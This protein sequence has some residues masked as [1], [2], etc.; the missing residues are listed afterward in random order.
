MKKITLLP[1]FL[2]GIYFGAFSQNPTQLASPAWVAPQNVNIQDPNFAL[3]VRATTPIINSGSWRGAIKVTGSEDHSPTIVWDRGGVIRNGVAAQNNFF[4]GG[5]ASSP[6]GDYFFGLQNGYGANVNESYVLQIYGQSRLN[7]PMMG[8]V[9]FKRNV[10]VQGS[11]GVGLLFPSEQLHTN[12]GV[13]FEGLTFNNKITNL[14]GIDANGKLWRAPLSS[15]G[16]QSNCL[17]TNFLTKTTSINTIGCSQIYD[18]GNFVGIS[19]TSPFIVNGTAS[20][21]NVNGLTV[22]NSLYVI[23]DEKYKSNINP[24]INATDIVSKLNPVTYEWKKSQFGDKNF[25]G[26]T[27]SGFIAQ[28]LEK[29]YPIAV[30]HDEKNNY[31]VNYNS[32]I[33]LL[34]KGQQEISQT[35]ISIKN[36]N[37]ELKNELNELKRLFYSLV[38]KSDVTLKNEIKGELSQNKPNPSSSNTVIQYKING[39]FNSGFIAIYDIKGSLL[40]LSKIASGMSNGVITFETKELSIGN[41]F[42]KLIIDGNEVDTKIMVIAR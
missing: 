6:T 32:I 30:A 36:E 1:F 34:T 17:T 26:N 33:P 28:Q 20:K 12:A 11:V 25:E 42:Y 27:Q 9:D 7:E 29:V 5:P 16:V 19:T 31:I 41:Y 22:T 40:R 18:D 37:R 4:I 15:G 35:I 39:K 13:R 3:T 23:S 38:S 10:L 24:I 14:V 2:L 21:L 8:S